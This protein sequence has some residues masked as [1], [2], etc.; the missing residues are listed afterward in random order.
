VYHRAVGLDAETLAQAQEGDGDARRAV[1]RALA[2]PVL[3]RVGGDE[4]LAIAA[5]AAV[6]SDLPRYALGAER[7]ESW[8]VTRA[9]KRAATLSAPGLSHT[10][11]PAPTTPELIDRVVDG[12]LA[13][14]VPSPFALELAQRRRASPAV[15]AAIVAGACVVTL[16]IAF[17]QT[18]PGPRGGPAQGSA[19]AGSATTS[20]SIA[21]G[22]AV[23]A[24]GAA[25]AWQGGAVEQRAG[26]VFYRIE[27][28]GAVTVRTPHGEVTTTRAC[29][30][31]SIDAGGAATSIT[32]DEGD[33]VI[34]GAKAT[35][36][37]ARRLP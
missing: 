22:T 30:R 2:P 3:A 11:H 26:S 19:A 34:G 12:A 37:D 20:I 6:M 36:G 8:A 24:A 17:I 13:A 5:L 29:L 4:A 10:M 32:I 16:V 31:V 1:A 18:T 27:P 15:I 14:G 28:G 25:I 21:R 9:G 35:A 23:L 33:A 7:L